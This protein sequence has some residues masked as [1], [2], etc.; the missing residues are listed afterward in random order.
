MFCPEFA[1][2]GSDMANGATMRTIP[3]A[4]I[5]QKYALRVISSSF[6]HDDRLVEER[7]TFR[8][9][10]QVLRNPSDIMDLVKYS[11]IADIPRGRRDVIPPHVSK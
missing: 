3:M 4:R 1:F 11:P 5:G 2:D 9:R 7:S 8:R 6:F 10:N